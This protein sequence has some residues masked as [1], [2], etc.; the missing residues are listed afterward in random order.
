MDSGSARRTS[1]GRRFSRA[2]STCSRSGG[3]PP[4]SIDEIVN[5]VDVSRK[6]F[7]RYFASKEDVIVRDEAHKIAIVDQALKTR[8]ADETVPRAVGRSLGVL[9]DY[10]ASEP[11]V[12][13]ALYRLGNAEPVLARRLLQHHATWQRA[14]GSLGRELAGE[15]SCHRHPTARH[16]GHGA[17][18]RA[19]RVVGVGCGGMCRQP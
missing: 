9:A 14:V 19:A 6:T 13:R 17:G 15:H 8:R 11:D 1:S 10:Y 7:F 12:V 18:G 16:S 3:S 2:P 5:A 4:A